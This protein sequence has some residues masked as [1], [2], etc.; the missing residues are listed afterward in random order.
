MTRAEAIERWESIIPTVFRS[1]DRLR[2]QLQKVL[3]KHKDDPTTG[4]ELYI[5]MIAEDIV[6]HTTD[7]ELA[8]L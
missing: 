8:K 7:E 5:H 4:A 2:P 6:S 1:E 3:E